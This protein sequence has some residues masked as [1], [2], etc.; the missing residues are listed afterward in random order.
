MHYDTW[1]FSQRIDPNWPGQLACYPQKWLFAFSIY[2]SQEMPIGQ[3]MVSDNSPFIV[4]TSWKGCRLISNTPFWNICKFTMQWLKM[5]PRLKL[6]SKYL[7]GA[8]CTHTED[9]VLLLRPRRR[10]FLW[11]PSKVLRLWSGCK[12]LPAVL[13]SVLITGHL[14]PAL[15]PHRSGCL[16]AQSSSLNSHVLPVKQLLFSMGV[17]DD[18]AQLC[19]FI[20]EPNIFVSVILK[21]WN[22]DSFSWEPWDLTKGQGER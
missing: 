19:N 9:N 1:Y 22:P 15:K 10:Y 5:F 14:Q 4:A 21:P 11:K 18:N 12:R 2:C 13:K 6:C 17:G 3:K 7:L 8:Y 16:A 20:V